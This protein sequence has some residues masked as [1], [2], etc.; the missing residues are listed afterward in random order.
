ML[1]AP[2]RL[3]AC[4]CV[5]L[6]WCDTGCVVWYLLLHCLM[7]CGVAAGAEPDLSG[8][9]RGVN[10]LLACQRRG[11]RQRHKWMSSLKTCWCAKVYNITQ[12]AYAIFLL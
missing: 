7:V 6:A 1:C 2:G 10:M 3:T 11:C 9:E 4:A 5:L 12:A 8:E